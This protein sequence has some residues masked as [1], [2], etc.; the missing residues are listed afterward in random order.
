M[1]IFYSITFVLWWTN[2]PHIL[3]KNPT[4]MFL[5]KIQKKKKDQ[6]QQF[7]FLSLKI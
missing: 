6:S 3:N 1:I 5:A 2:T 4:I 7:N